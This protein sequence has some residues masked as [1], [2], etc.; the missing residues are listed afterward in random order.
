M[1][2]PASVPP[3]PTAETKASTLPPVC[4]QISGPVEFDVR[5]PVGDVVEL[6]RPDRAAFLRLGK[7]LG[8][9]P[10]NLH[11]IVGVPVGDGGHLDERRAAH[12]KRQLLLLRLRLGNDDDGSGSRAPW[13][14]AS[15][16]CRYCRRCP[17]TIVPPGFSAPARSAARTIHSA[18]RSF[19]DWPGLRNSALP[20]ISQPVASEARRSRRSGVF[21]MRSRT[22]GTIGIEPGLG[23]C[24][25]SYAR[26]ARG[27]RRAVLSEG[28]SGEIDPAQASVIGRRNRRRPCGPEK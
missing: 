25:A 16:R 14:R 11:V 13:R 1:P 19:T 9:A 23:F 18:A 12:P 26:E 3:V 20:R 2:T 8:Q 5:L 4:S 21:P 17:S 7:L 22:E 15:G 10:G 27:A 28:R 6:V 24:A